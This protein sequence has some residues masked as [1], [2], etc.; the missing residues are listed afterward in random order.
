MKVVTLDSHRQVK[1]SLCSGLVAASLIKNAEVEILDLGK[2]ID[3]PLVVSINIMFVT[4]EPKPE[5]VTKE[6]NSKKKIIQNNK[7]KTTL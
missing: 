2:E 1:Q 7:N 5:P 3:Y 4:P 6:N